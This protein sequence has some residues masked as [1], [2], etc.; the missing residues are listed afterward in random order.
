MAALPSVFGAASP[1]VD[2]RSPAQRTAAAVRIVCGTFAVLLVIALGVLLFA[3]PN[4][5]EVVATIQHQ[6]ARTFWYGML[7]QLVVLPVL[8]LLIVALALSLIGILL[9]PFA[10]VAYAIACA[11][12]VTLGFL[13]VARL[14]GGA[15]WHGSDSA[16][17]VR[18]LGALA[19]GIAVFFG[20][21]IIAALLTWAPLAATVVHAAALAATW[22]AMTLGLGAAIL[23]RAGTHRRVAGA[24]RPVE[25]AAWQTPTPV[26]GVVAARRTATREA[27]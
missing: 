12:L 17:R 14:V 3:G 23:S 10:I 18:A 9:I 1:V 21:W 20:L 5:D 16:V 4:L 26:V 8:L 22:S 2:T 11:G 7:G 19:I 25:L 24:A 15:I 27:R 6:F 13:A